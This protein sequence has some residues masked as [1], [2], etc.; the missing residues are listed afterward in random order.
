MLRTGASPPRTGT[1][2]YGVRAVFGTWAGMHPDVHASLGMDTAFLVAGPA[3]C[4]SGTASASQW[5]SLPSRLVQAG[6]RC[7]S[8]AGKFAC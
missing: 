3:H 8:G 6:A 2:H 4:L 5:L 7:R 1:D